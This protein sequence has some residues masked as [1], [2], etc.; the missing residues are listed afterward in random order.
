MIGCSIQIGI[1]FNK[2]RAL[3][4]GIS[5]SGSSICSVLLPILL[6]T[7]FSS[8]GWRGTL[9]ILSGWTLNIT[10]CGALIR[11]ISIY[12]VKEPRGK[13]VTMEEVEI[14]GS[15]IIEESSQS[16][17]RTRN[18][19]QSFFH[20]YCI[21]IILGF[22]EFLCGFAMSIPTIYI[23]P[24]AKELGYDD[25]Q[26]AYLLSA[27]SLGDFICRLFSGFMQSLLPALTKRLLLCMSTILFCISAI[28]VIAAT[29]TGYGSLLA[30]AIAY[31]SLFGLYLP[32]SLSSVAVLLGV[33]N[34]TKFIGPRVFANGIGA[35]ISP[36]IAGN[37]IL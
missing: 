5:S 9:L 31:G 17:S 24:F 18:S 14:T 8:F 23:V 7:L 10:V 2:W 15:Q 26:A 34:I 4:Y 25:V 35:L 21:V 30:F 36:P 27:I 12:K 20:K 16:A 13:E 32:F 33:E 6:P 11:P 22:G 3:A 19:F 1:Y 37:A 29:A 28:T